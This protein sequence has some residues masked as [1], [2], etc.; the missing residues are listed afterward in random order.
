[1]NLADAVCILVYVAGFLGL[2][3]ALGRRIGRVEAKLVSTLRSVRASM[4][5]HRALLGVATKEAWI[6]S[7]QAKTIFEPY[8]RLAEGS[9]DQL[10]GEIEPTG[11]P[12]TREEADLVASYLARAKEHGDLGYD[13][14]LAFYQVVRRISGEEPNSEQWNTLL[15]L[16]AHLLGRAEK[17]TDTTQARKVGV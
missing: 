2:L 13:D 16:A 1:M 12:V 6:T 9:L 8:Q 17:T 11:N 3:L 10:I 15:E 14:A 7:E 5:S 4:V